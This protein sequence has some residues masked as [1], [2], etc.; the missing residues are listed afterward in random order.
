[1]WLVNAVH[2]MSGI[3]NY[4]IIEFKSILSML[5]MAKKR[6]VKIFFPFLV[7][8]LPSSTFR[9]HD[10]ESKSILIIVVI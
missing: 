7:G 5:K 1:M 10:V 9:T 6:K 2:D 3:E 4:S 8:I